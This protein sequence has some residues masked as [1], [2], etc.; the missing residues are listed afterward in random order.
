V[1]NAV[2]HSFQPLRRRPPAG[3]GR[4]RDGRGSRL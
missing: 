2:T 1:A 3:P 4:R